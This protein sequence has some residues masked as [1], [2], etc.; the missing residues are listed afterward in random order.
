MALNQSA[1][2]V[3]RVALVAARAIRA[4]SADAIYEYLRYTCTRTVQ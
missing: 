4:I 1:A 2:D 3:A